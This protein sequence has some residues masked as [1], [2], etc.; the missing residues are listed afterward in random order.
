MAN[1]K[2]STSSLGADTQRL[3]QYGLLCLPPLRQGATVSQQPQTLTGLSP[4][5]QT[6]QSNI[7]TD[8]HWASQAWC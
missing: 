2:P 4:S 5:E 6:S 1:A 7:T 8:I 3:Q